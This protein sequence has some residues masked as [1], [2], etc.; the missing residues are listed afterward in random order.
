MFSFSSLLLAFD[1]LGLLFFP[2]GLDLDFVLVVLN[3]GGTAI[4]ALHWDEF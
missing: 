4:V 2:T 1:G 3:L